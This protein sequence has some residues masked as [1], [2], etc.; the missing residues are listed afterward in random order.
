MWTCNCPGHTLRVSDP[1]LQ[2]H[3]FISLPWVDFRDSFHFGRRWGDVVLT[4]GQTM[5]FLVPEI[6]LVKPSQ[7][8]VAQAAVPRKEK[9]RT[10]DR[11]FGGHTMPNSATQMHRASREFPAQQYD[12]LRQPVSD[13]HGESST[14]DGRSQR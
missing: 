5:E 13:Q 9:E 8:T 10:A 7:A 11:Q 4:A 3:S 6:G 2:G 1:G 12:H 14:A